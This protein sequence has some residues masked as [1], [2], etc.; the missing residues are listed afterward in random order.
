MQE[1]Q[2]K[3]FTIGELEGLSTKQIEAHLGLYAGYVKN[4]N[5]VMSLIEEMKKDAEANAYQLSEVK[6]RFGFEFNGMRLHELYFEQFEASDNASEN[7]KAA[8]V[9]QYGSYEA[10]EAEFKAVGKMRGVG[11]ALLIQDERTGH[12]HTNW[13]SDHEVGHLGGQKILLAMDIWEHAFL[14]DYLPSERGVYIDAF[15]KN[16]QWGVV[17]ERFVA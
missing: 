2:K 10:W 6:R 7:L 8:L 12:L 3:E 5:K 13:V 14:V 9:K 11:W 17:E 4:T 1:Y 16:L 15:F